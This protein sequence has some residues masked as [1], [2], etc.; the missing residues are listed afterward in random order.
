MRGW[1][2]RRLLVRV[3]VLLDCEAGV[4]KERL[5]RMRKFVNEI[6]AVLGI[7]ERKKYSELGVRIPHILKKANCVEI[8]LALE[9]AAVS[10]NTCFT[11]N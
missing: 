1:V 8:Q 10:F 3:G 4:E 11:G 6:A 2:L 7:R 5:I 9:F